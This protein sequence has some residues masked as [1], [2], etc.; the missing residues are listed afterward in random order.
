MLSKTITLSKTIMLS[1]TILPS[2]HDYPVFNPNISPG[3][4]SNAAATGK[5]AASTVVE[6]AAN[7]LM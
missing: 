1:K 4:N 2:L 6:C 5:P 3:M 7:L